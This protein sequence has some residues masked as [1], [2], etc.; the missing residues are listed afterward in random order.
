MRNI[1]VGVI[2]VGSWGVNHVEAYR[3]LPNAE[4]VAVADSSPGRAREIAN[5]YDIP[6]WFDSYEELCALR[7]LDAVSIVTPESEH[8]EPV[9]SAAKAGKH[10]LIEKPVARAVP[11]IERMITAA[12]RAD[13]ILMPGHLLR[14]D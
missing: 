12:R 3:T 8:V 13:V 7:E 14:F 5:T 9:E 4:I 6:H 2:G 1:K 10:I 11:D